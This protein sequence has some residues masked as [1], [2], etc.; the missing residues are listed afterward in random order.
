MISSSEL[1]KNRQLL[2]IVLQHFNQIS[3]SLID[4]EGDDEFWVGLYSYSTDDF[5]IEPV[6]KTVKLGIQT[7]L[8]KFENDYVIVTPVS[9]H[10]QIVR[11]VDTLKKLKIT[12]SQGDVNGI[13]YSE[14]E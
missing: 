8:R 11:Y 7:A 10:S 6:S 13:H 5:H 2:N 1:S 9:F 3:D 14:S 4:D 12:L